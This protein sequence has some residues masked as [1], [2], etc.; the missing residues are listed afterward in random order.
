VEVVRLG[1]P[2]SRAVVAQAASGAVFACPG[3]GSL[4]PRDVEPPPVQLGYSRYVETAAV[5]FCAFDAVFILAALARCHKH[6][7]VKA[8][9]VRFIADGRR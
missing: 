7:V 4:P 5:V 9:Q 8:A 3:C 1:D 6:P 2:A